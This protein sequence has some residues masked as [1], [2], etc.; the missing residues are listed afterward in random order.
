[1]RLPQSNYSDAEFNALYHQRKLYQWHTY[2]GQIFIP[3]KFFNGKILYTFKIVITLEADII[4]TREDNRMKTTRRG[5]SASW[6]DQTINRSDSI[7]LADRG[8]LLE[9]NWSDS[10][11]LSVK[12][13]IEVHNLESYQYFLWYQ[14]LFLHLFCCF[15]NSHPKYKKTSILGR[16]TTFTTWDYILFGSSFGSA[17]HFQTKPKYDGGNFRWMFGYTMYSF[18]F[19]W[20]NAENASIFLRIVHFNL[21]FINKMMTS[22]LGFWFKIFGRSGSSGSSSYVSVS[23]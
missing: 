18:N 5:R 6:I 12:D 2:Y 22:L 10:L 3:S 19:E 15:S 1:M 11:P 23:A 20:F 14:L 13:I 7:L 8:S 17:N 9:R 4:T 16:W 21:Q